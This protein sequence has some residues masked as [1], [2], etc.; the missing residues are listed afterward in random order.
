MMGMNLD[1]MVCACVCVCE[2]E[3]ERERESLCSDTRRKI[4]GQFF[5]WGQKLL[6]GMSSQDFGKQSHF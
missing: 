4:Y 6:S 1:R 2:R 5:N 3:R